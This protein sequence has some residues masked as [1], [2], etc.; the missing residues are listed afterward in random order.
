MK[1]NR[2]IC[3]SFAICVLLGGIAESTA[4]TKTAT[5]DPY[6]G[7]GSS[8]E[9]KSDLG[10][11]S[12]FSNPVARIGASDGPQNRSSIVKQ[13]QQGGNQLVGHESPVR[14]VREPF[15]VGKVL[16]L[17]GGEPI[18]VGDLMFQI[19]QA[20]ESRIPD[21]PEKIKEQQRQAAIPQLLPQFVQAK[22][23]YMGAVRE[24]PD[25]VDLE[26]VFES[27][28][29]QFDEKAL[30]KMMETSGVKNAV[31]FDAQLRGQDYS[32]RQ[33]RR[34]WAIQQFTRHSVGLKLRDLPETT[35][36]EML[37]RYQDNIK[38]YDRPARA[39]W[40]QVMVSYS[41]H[42]TKNDARKKI[43]TLGNKIVNGANFAAT[44]KEASDGYKASNG[45]Q[46][47]W[48]TQGALALKPLD[49]AI[50]ELPLNE[51]SRVIETSQ[52]LHIVRVIE[53]EKAS[54]TPFLEAQVDIKKA[55]EVEKREAA[56]K[57][58]NEK[59]RREIPVEYLVNE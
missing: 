12:R 38:D 24:L 7:S 56:F 50:F 6:F 33:L 46:H 15:Q 25:E 22:L 37:Q 23:L 13:P 51:L 36:H 20:I 18:F 10:S 53:R 43:V 44:A 14:P 19:N 45:G 52:G 2:L 4:Q 9:S 16:A 39:K 17:V 28:G 32:L 40:E 54:R 34:S 49:K 47:D 8:V 35:H 3:A 31:E 55:L 57:K 5:P 41:K 42:S 58:Y 11:G 30:P 1:N 21:A 27:V 48:T 59:L 29:E 26:Q